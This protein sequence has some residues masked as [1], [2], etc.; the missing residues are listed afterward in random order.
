MTKEEILAAMK[1]K[2]DISGNDPKFKPSELKPC[3]IE[4]KENG[5]CLE[6]GS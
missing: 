3:S 5:N 2:Y 1:E 6:C 4:D